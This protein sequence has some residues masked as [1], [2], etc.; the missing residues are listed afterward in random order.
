MFASPTYTQTLSESAAP[1]TSVLTVTASDADQAANALVHYE[2]AP[3]VPGD[4]DPAAFLV[5]PETGEIT[6]RRSLDHETQAQYRFLAVATDSGSTA[7]SSTAQV[8][9]KVVPL[10]EPRIQ[11]WPPFGPD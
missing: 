4:T 9:V 1:G 6:L 3:L 2:L 8:L 7:L 10:C 5:H 11:I